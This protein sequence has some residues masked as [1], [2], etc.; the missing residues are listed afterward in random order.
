MVEDFMLNQAEILVSAPGPGP[1]VAGRPG[2]KLESHPVHGSEE[3]QAYD[4]MVQRYRLF[5]SRPFVERVTRM[6]LAS[7]R[8]LDIGT[9]PGWIPIELAGRRPRWYIEAVDPSAEMLRRA[10]AHA[11]AEGVGER[12][13]F[14]RGS[15]GDLPFEHDSFDLVISNFVLHHLERP[16]AMF[17]EVARVLRVGGRVV[18]RDLAR[19][20]PWKARLL[21][22][23]A[24]RVLRQTEAQVRLY[25]GSL[26]AALT[27]A[28]ARAAL[29]A[30][31]L[32]R[33]RVRGYLGHELLITV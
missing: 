31:R 5:M 19:P 32:C 20:R 7:G 9:G 33:G 15:A 27:I 2:R 10:R 13:R 4:A 23:L 12:V 25:K 17:D 1:A 11:A 28:E 26:D 24:G 14:R 21:V 29:R 30:S 8:V 16:E 22:A 6:P 3:V 18:I